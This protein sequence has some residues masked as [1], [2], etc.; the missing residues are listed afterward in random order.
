[1][2]KL[3]LD[4]LKFKFYKYGI[5]IACLFR[6]DIKLLLLIIK[7]IHYLVLKKKNN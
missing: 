2:E 5:N 1:M 7:Y 3:N 6:I 4:Q